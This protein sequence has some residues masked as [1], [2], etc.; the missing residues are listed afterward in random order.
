MGTMRVLSSGKALMIVSAFLTATG[1]LFWKWGLTE[2][3]Y[4]AA[5]FVCYGIGAVCM[6]KAFAV[7][8]LSVA[9]PLLCT[10]YIFALAYGAFFLGEEISLQKVLAV[11]LLGIGVTLTSYGK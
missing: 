1:Q 6:L 7:E 5:G 8:K 10:G 2:P 4:M 9:Y 11:V 3:L